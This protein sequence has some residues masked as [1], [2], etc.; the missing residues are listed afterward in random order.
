MSL[1]VGVIRINYDKFYGIILYLIIY[2]CAAWSL[3]LKEEH[4]LREFENAVLW[5]VFESKRVDMVRGQRRLQNEEFHHLYSSAN[6]IR[7]IKLWMML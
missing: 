7:M 4:R 1:G 5:A 6:I 2:G 3:T